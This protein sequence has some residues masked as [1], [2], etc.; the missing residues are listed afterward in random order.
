ME[1]SQAAP[2]QTT[3]KVTNMENSEETKDVSLDELE[4]QAKV[5]LSAGDYE[6]AV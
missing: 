6:N 4:S 1:T 3:N 5:C 2:D